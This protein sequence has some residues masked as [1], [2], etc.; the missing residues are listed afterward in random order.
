MRAP[1]RWVLALTTAFRVC[2]DRCRPAGEKLMA[3]LR[4]ILHEVVDAVFALAFRSVLY[5]TLAGVEVIAAMTARRSAG[6][7]VRVVCV[8]NVVTLAHD[9]TSL[10]SAYVAQADTTR[11]SEAVTTHCSSPSYMN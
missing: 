8:L 2:G 1:A 10:A 4:A 6:P 11:C 3:T 9:C 5:M 7:P